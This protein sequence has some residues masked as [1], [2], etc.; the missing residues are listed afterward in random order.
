MKHKIFTKDG[1]AEL[2]DADTSHVIAHTSRCLLY[3]SCTAHSDRLW[4]RQFC[5]DVDG[6]TIGRFLT[7]DEAHR[8][9]MEAK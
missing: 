6:T 3:E 1:R 4:A 2:V 8:V 9:F 5:V 7:L